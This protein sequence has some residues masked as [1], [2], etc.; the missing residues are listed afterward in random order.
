M[1]VFEYFA[2]TARGKKKKGLLLADFKT[3]VDDELRKNGFYPIKIHQ[4]DVLPNPKKVSKDTLLGLTKD[5]YQLLK[6]KISLYE[7]LKNILQRKTDANVQILLIAI[8]DKIKQ[9]Y[10]FSNILQQYPGIFDAVYI[11]I[12]KAGEESGNLELS[13]KFL[14]EILEKQGQVQK[15]IR[16]QLAYPK[17]LALIGLCLVIGVLT[18]LVPSFKDLL[19]GKEQ[20]GITKIVFL[21]SDFLLHSPEI[22]IASLL[23]LFASLY[24][25]L[26]ID[27]VKRAFFELQLKIFPFKNFYIPKIFSRF[28]LL[29]HSLLLAG[30][31]TVEALQH[32]KGVL[33]NPIL[34]KEMEKIIAQMKEGK[35]LSSELKRSSWIPETVC[36]IVSSRDDIGDLPEAFMAIYQLYEEELDK[37]LT[38]LSTYIQPVLFILLGLI[39]GLIIL[40]VLL[41]MTDATNF[42]T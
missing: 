9:G 15:K 33:G 38:T 17:F 32:A 5:L 31:T 25:I 23:G 40:S 27:K 35:R 12:I 8:L 14:K 39:I 19:D 30:I 11:A 10:L 28:S 22:I 2:L 42:T 7:S 4:L 41:P 16:S 37:N 18:I 21:A 20:K 1:P 24:S 6:A 26:K 3:A 29:V 36:Q 13:L 34:E